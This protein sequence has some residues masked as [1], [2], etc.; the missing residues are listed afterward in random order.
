MKK[1]RH[2]LMFVATVVMATCCSKGLGKDDIVDPD[3][4]IDDET[5]PVPVMFASPQVDVVTK[6]G[7]FSQIGSLNDLT[8]GVI[9]VG[10][11]TDWS[12]TQ[13][14]TVFNLSETL[15]SEGNLE[16]SKTQYYPM[17]SQD[18]YSFY[19][20][21]YGGSGR[22][23]LNAA[24]DAY[25]I[26]SQSNVGYVDILWAKAV[27]NPYN[28]REGFNAAY[29]R[30]LAKDL[31][32]GKIED[33]EDYNSYLPKLDFKH[34]LSCID[35]KIKYDNEDEISEPATM[36]NITVY[37]FYFT[38]VYT[39]IKLT[40]AKNGMELDDVVSLNDNAEP[41][42]LHFRTGHSD[43]SPGAM[44]LNQPITTDATSLGYPILVY[45]GANN[46]GFEGVLELNVNGV[47][48]TISNL[49]FPA[50]SGEDHKGYKPN[51]KYSYT[52]LIKDPQE[53]K[54]VKTSLEDFVEYD[55]GE[56]QQN[57]IN[58]TQ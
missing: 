39:N 26:S 54:I 8:I 35:V 47:T 1:F 7:K 44:N 16:F 46:D 28:S 17:S 30:A 48:A 36:E 42:E 55:W 15:T 9:C 21:R 33:E 27:A 18:N 6:A 14:G 43:T 22:A 56:E 38:N 4:W 45:A 58:A 34:A 24:K 13:N 50:P 41:G 52:I 57:L 10:D 37:R 40:V 32:S 5:L 20:Y 12:D 2:I 25:E 31:K 11:Q 3:A 29:S 19:A 23:I 51:T 53:I 49:K